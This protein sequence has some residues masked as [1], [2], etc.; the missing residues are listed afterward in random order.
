MIILLI[1]VLNAANMFVGY[2]FTILLR[3]LSMYK[4]FLKSDNLIV[5]FLGNAPSG[6][7]HNYRDISPLFGN[8]QNNIEMWERAQTTSLLKP[9]KIMGVIFGVI[10]LALISIAG[11]W[12]VLGLL[13]ILIGFG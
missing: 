5:V 2:N 3:T 11:W 10:F 4:K 9:A 6:S 13:G 8:Y 1:I 12:S 7:F